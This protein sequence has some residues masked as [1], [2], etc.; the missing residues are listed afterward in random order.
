MHRITHVLV[1][2]AA[3]SAARAELVNQRWAGKGTPATFADTMKVVQSGKDLRLVFDL[4]ALPKGAKIRHASL[5][6]FTQNDRQ[7]D[8]PAVIQ[9][10]EKPGAQNNAVLAGS[11][12]RLEGP[13]FRSFDATP[14]VERWAAQPDKDLAF[15][16]VNF[17]K[18]LAAKSYLEVLYEAPATSSL[19]LPPQVGGLRTVHHDGQTF[20]IWKEHPAFVPKS[21]DIVWVEQWSEREDKVADGPGTGAFGRPR[22]P[23]ITCKTFRDLQGLGGREKPSGF[24]GIKPLVRVKE[25]P[26]VQYRIYRHSQ[27]ITAAN[28]AQ[29]ERVA[30]VEPLNAYD[31]N[32]IK[33]NFKGEYIDQ[34]EVADSAIPTFCYKD[35]KAVAPGEGLHVHTAPADGKFF[36]AVTCSL[37]G[38]ENLTFSA[39][40]SLAVPVEEKVAPP[41]PVL[42]FVQVDRYKDDV[43]EHWFKYWGGPPYYHLPVKMFRLAVGV[44]PKLAGPRPMNII[45]ISDSFNMR[46]ILNLPPA[47]RITLAVEQ[48]HGWMPDLCYNEGQGTLR[49][50]SECKV[51][52]FSERHMLNQI[53]WA[54]KKWDIDRLK[55][56]GSMLHF[57]LRHPEIFSVMSFGAYTATYDYRWAPGSPVMPGILGPKGIKTVSGEDAWSE[58]SAGWYVNRYPQRDIPFLI[59]QSNVGKDSGHT[60][61]FGWQDDPRGWSQLLTGRATFVASWSTDF[62][63]ELHEGLRDVDW[64][65]TIPAFSYCSLDN[66][67]GNGDPSDGDYYGTINGWLL[68]QNDSLDEPGRWEM[69]VY[70]VPSCARDQ[71]TVDVTPR[72]A[73]AFKA[74]PGEKFQWTNTSVG[75]GKTVATGVATADAAG[76]VTIPR[77]VVG[78]GKNRLV[79]VK[80]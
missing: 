33:T 75:S 6:C 7:P 58:F 1:L 68:W 2:V 19:K 24:Q 73:K 22:L 42:Q 50:A 11:S 55:I 13:W 18:L 3:A 52:Y 56:V 62:C 9:A 27:P 36:Y 71:C 20:I 21:E 10:A 78:K 69:T 43:E 4:S 8:R 51:D 60:S 16:V 37:A 29:A 59:C 28:L 46:G 80:Q 35:C 65:K 66:N 17:D 12:L 25:V 57:G 14:A 76:L 26:A 31:S 44:P 49:A 72:H 53:Q 45:T 34:Y 79:L 39:A 23:A 38:N 5:Y 70:L 67:P 64:N 32:M 63:P 40:N 74:R 41:Q 30:A 48:I 47:N 15:A 54:M 61:E 77:A